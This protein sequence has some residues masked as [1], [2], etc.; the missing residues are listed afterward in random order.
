MNSFSSRRESPSFVNARVHGTEPILLFRF[1]SPSSSLLFCYFAYHIFGEN[2]R[3][4]ITIFIC[5]QIHVHRTHLIFSRF[6]PYDGC[7]CVC[8][9]LVRLYRTAVPLSTTWSV[10]M[11]VCV[12]MCCHAIHRTIRGAK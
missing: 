3:L 4:K 1:S 7:L 12:C 2:V 6:H 8:V 9:C 11:C 5:M 10:G